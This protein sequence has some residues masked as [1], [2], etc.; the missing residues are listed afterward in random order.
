M[1]RRRVARGLALVSLTLSVTL[2]HAAPLAAEPRGAAPELEGS[3]ARIA[4]LEARLG[5]PATR[6]QPLACQLNAAGECRDRRD[7]YRWSKPKR[8]KLRDHEPESPPPIEARPGRGDDPELR[9]L[10]DS[11]IRSC[12]ALVA[13]PRAAALPER[14]ACLYRLAALYVDRHEPARALPHLVRLLER[15]DGSE[16]A[17]WA[18]ELMLSVLL[19]RWE[20]PP[21]EDVDPVTPLDRWHARLPTMSLWRHPAAK[22]RLQPL[23]A[24]LEPG[25]RWRVGMRYLETGRA[26]VKDGGW[27]LLDPRTVDAFTRCA[28]TFL[29][30]HG[31][32]GARHDL[33]DT[34][35]WNASYCYE[36]AQE[37]ELAMATRRR[38]LARYPDSNHY[39]RTLAQ[40]AGN[41]Q[42]LGRYEESAAL[43]EE[44]AARY[45][46]DDRSADMLLDAYRF[47][48]GLGQTRRAREDLERYV[49][50]FKRKHPR[51][52]ARYYWLIGD[53]LTRD[54]ERIEHAEEYLRVFSKLGGNALRVVIH[55]RRGA[56]AWRASCRRGDV[57][58]LCAI[59]A[60]RPSA[61]LTL[62]GP[63]GQPRRYRP[64]MIQAA[65]RELVADAALAQFVV[66]SKLIRHRAELPLDDQPLVQAHRDAV[67]AALAYTTDAYFEAL[68][69]QLDQA[70]GAALAGVGS[71]RG[72]FPTPRPSGALVL[73]HTQRAALGAPQGLM[74]AVERLELRYRSL[75][76]LPYPTPWKSVARARMGLL[77]EWLLGHLVIEAKGRPPPPDVVATLTAD[78]RAQYERC[79]R[80]ERGAAELAAAAFCQARLRELAPG[81]P[82][83][84]R[85]LL[86]RDRTCESCRPDAVELAQVAGVVL[87]PPVDETDE[88]RDEPPG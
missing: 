10:R 12:E 23:H 63:H 37:L 24:E 73:S 60:P 69:R 30:L 33:A 62:P 58:G 11:L 21:P 19:R 50:L 71:P 5:E 72:D 9:V 43:C 75:A 82:L 22:E 49:E 6:P 84:V 1:L 13:E 86:L 39:R 3:R 57:A 53:L 74:E 26:A 47:R 88:D 68:A 48:L 42:A 64:P 27:G 59:V 85:E 7:S 20:W 18:A 25:L 70:P 81:S 66:V 29:E 77:R 28:E 44:Y 78:A 61:A 76:A 80:P 34:L 56:L 45:A 36:G 2:P 14:D 31:D 17:V 52:A 65:A 41:L 16:R 79:L 51:K 67:G 40:L 15:D 35:L 54:A 83:V 4:D 46:R 8:A 87:E 32:Y 55:A 38:L